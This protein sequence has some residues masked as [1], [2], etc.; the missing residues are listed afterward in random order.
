ML[1]FDR[2]YKWYMSN[3]EF[4]HLQAYFETILFYPIH[5]ILA[6]SVQE[7]FQT[8]VA[9]SSFHARIFSAYQN[10]TISN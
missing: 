1:I 7:R 8:S 6:S 10:P 5:S 9:W 3:G 4:V 2:L